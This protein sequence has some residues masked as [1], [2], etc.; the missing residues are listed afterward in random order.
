[1][2]L[3]T[4]S[5]VSERDG[6]YILSAAEAPQPILINVLYEIANK[7]AMFQAVTIGN[8]AT[9]VKQDVVTL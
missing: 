1:P 3:Q 7:R 2:A 8:V 4:L 9:L 6:A 5:S